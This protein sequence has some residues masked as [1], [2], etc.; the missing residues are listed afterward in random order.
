MNKKDIKQIANEI[1]YLLEVYD[2]ALKENDQEIAAKTLQCIDYE[3]D[4][5]DSKEIKIRTLKQ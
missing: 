3:L 2:N 5:L 1:D 4:K